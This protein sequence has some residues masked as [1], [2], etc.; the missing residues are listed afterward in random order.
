MSHDIL[1]IREMLG[2]DIARLRYIRRF[3]TCRTVSEETVAEHVAFVSIFCVLVGHWA[4]A[5]GQD[6][7]M[8]TLLTRAALHD[9]EEAR[10]G[11]FP[12]TFKHSSH[13]LREAVEKSAKKECRTIF[14]EIFMG[15]PI[16]QNMFHAWESAKD[17]TVEGAILE[18]CDFLSALAFVCEEKKMGNFC[19]SQHTGTF[20]AYLCI[21]DQERYQFLRPLVKQA[22]TLVLEVMA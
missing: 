10:T 12:R 19:L 2:G 21:F 9:I 17:D 13:E 16:I 15:E 18:F 20:G 3:S 22:H 4:M 8:G 14:E 6:V 5:N 7:K 11:D 1:N